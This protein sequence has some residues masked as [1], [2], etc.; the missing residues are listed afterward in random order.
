MYKN[1]VVTKFLYEFILKHIAAQATRN[2]NSECSEGAVSQITVRT[3]T[4]SV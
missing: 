3:V 1:F 4:S 2:I